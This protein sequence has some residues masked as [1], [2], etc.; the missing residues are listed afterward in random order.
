MNT[1]R[2]GFKDS[3]CDGGPIRNLLMLAKLTHREVGKRLGISASAASNEIAGRRAWTKDEVRKLLHLFQQAR[4]SERHFLS[5]RD[6]FRAR[7]R[8]AGVTYTKAIVTSTT[9]TTNTNT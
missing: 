9:D 6:F 8:K 3:G 4:L 5:A 1:P 2:R 7:K